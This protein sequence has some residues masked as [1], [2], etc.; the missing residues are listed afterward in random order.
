MLRNHIYLDYNASTP[1]HAEVLEAMLPFF[2]QY[3]GNPAS[4][5]HAH[6]WLAAEAI[7]IAREQVA[8]LIGSE[9]DEIIF[10]SGATESLNLAIQGV[11][12]AYE[13]KGKHIVTLSTEH[14]AVLDT[15]GF[16]ERNGWEITYL[17]VD[18]DGYPDEFLL[19][20][21][22]RK[23]TIAFIGML[24]NNESGRILP[25]EKYAQIAKEKDVFVI[26]DATQAS[27][28]IK[29]DV[30]LLH[31]DLLALSGHKMYAPKGVGALFIRR[32]NPRVKLLPM[33]F[34]GGHERG[35]RPGTPATPLIVGLGKAADLASNNLVQW[36]SLLSKTRDL[37]ESELLKLEGVRL[38]I[39]DASRLPNTSNLCI[40]GIHADK[41]FPQVP[42]LSFSSG[43]ACSSALPE[44]SHV[45]LAM[46]LNKVDAFASIRISTGI[47]TS[48]NEVIA[49][50]ST[51]KEVVR[52][53]R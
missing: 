42:L 3:Y 19:R 18:S 29:V 48:T 53:L 23:D 16:L 51:L 15:C 12:K 1:V 31:V 4:K 30:N 27:G 20:N 45:L 40:E 50:A 28:K 44:P 24:A 52:K 25:L 10:T 7:D 41:L 49:S 43:S 33:I 9:K 38:L 8:K 22:L 47:Y 39:K 36:N 35:L 26:C 37:F 46:G 13:S 34:G 2:T 32:K 6:G 21:S 17:P 11:A 14:K 5:T